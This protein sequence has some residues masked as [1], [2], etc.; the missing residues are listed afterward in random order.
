M[1]SRS[2]GPHH[3]GL[4][5]DHNKDSVVVGQWTTCATVLPSPALGLLGGMIGQNPSVGHIA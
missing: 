2:I 3:D 1:G 5:R 4:V